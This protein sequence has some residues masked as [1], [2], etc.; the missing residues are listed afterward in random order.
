MLEIGAS[1]SMS[2][3]EK[4]SKTGIRLDGR[5]RTACRTEP[6]SSI[7]AEPVRGILSGTLK[8]LTGGRGARPG[9]KFVFR[10][11]GFSSSVFRLTD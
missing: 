5:G 9:Q 6:G 11:C 3:K 7:P 1:G 4:W 10:P 2:W 8:E